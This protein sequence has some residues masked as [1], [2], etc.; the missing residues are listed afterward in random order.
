MEKTLNT[1]NNNCTNILLGTMTCE[2]E[3]CTRNTTISN[4]RYFDGKW[5]CTF[6][7]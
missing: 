3:N 7:C 1:N 6:P 2:H 5:Y 4:Q